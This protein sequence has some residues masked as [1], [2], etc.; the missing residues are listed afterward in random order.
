MNAIAS[1]VDITA[2][3]P[4]VALHNIKL[5][6]L[7]QRAG[8]MGKPA[9]AANSAPFARVANMDMPVV[10]SLALPFT[11]NDVEFKILIAQRG[12]RT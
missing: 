11:R 9:F 12:E 4:L 6:L 3:N 10:L 7:P 1:A 2:R 8:S 5:L